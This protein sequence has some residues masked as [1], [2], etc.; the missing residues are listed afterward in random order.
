MKGLLVDRRPANI[1]SSPVSFF[2]P[3]HLRLAFVFAFPYLRRSLDV[4]PAY[5][6]LPP[7]LAKR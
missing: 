7:L 5:N 1:D 3:E 6:P 4:G 2:F